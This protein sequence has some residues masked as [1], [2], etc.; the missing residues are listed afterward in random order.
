MVKTPHLECIMSSSFTLM[1]DC[2]LRNL[3]MQLSRECSIGIV[4]THRP[5]NRGYIIF[6]KSVKLP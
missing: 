4:V 2:L 1:D 5:L 6:E 3:G